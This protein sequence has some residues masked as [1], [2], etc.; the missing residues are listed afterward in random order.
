M[1]QPKRE[2]GVVG[3]AKYELRLSAEKVPSEGFIQQFIRLPKHFFDLKG[4][5]KT[6]C[7]KLGTFWLF[8]VLF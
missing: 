7:G 3:R 2:G 5:I 6:W 8:K 1:F 4:K